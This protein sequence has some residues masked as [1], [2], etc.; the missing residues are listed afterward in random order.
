MF[1]ACIITIKRKKTIVISYGAFVMTIFLQENLLG[2][3]YLTIE[4]I[5][6]NV[7]S[8]DF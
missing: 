7:F 4:K 3:S 5:N 1:K 6:T 8:N 2:S